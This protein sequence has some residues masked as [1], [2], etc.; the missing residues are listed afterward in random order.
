MKFNLTLK[1]TRNAPATCE[2][3]GDKILC[4]DVCLSRS[5]DPDASSFNTSKPYVIGHE[6]GP[7][8]MV[9]AAHE[10]DALD[11]AVDANMLDCLMADN[12]DCDRDSEGYASLGNAGEAFNLDYAWMAEVEIDP[13]RDIKLI[14]K[15]VRASEAGLNNVDA[16]R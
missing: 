3:E 11:N 10:Q 15:L 13:A 14:V 4:N 8:C 2:L 12:E 7:I 1:N 5:I 6:F 16:W 9:W